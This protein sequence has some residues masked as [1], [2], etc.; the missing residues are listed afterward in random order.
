MKKKIY[1]L[2]LFFIV[3]A[4]FST[5]VLL[6]AQANSIWTIAE[7]IRSVEDY[8]VVWISDSQHHVHFIGHDTGAY[9]DAIQILNE[10]QISR[11]SIGEYTFGDGSH[12]FVLEG[13]TDHTVQYFLFDEDFTKVWAVDNSWIP[14]HSEVTQYE[15]I[16]PVY[17]V[18]NPWIIKRFFKEICDLDTKY[19]FE[20]ST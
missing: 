12:M 16:C 5:S 17:R 10:L 6:L 13:S 14:D 2:L 4:M 19:D 7:S 20:I 9:S 15:E 1:L 8:P 11:K 18:K 3:I